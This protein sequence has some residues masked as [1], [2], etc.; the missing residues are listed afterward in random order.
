MWYPRDK[1]QEPV[2]LHIELPDGYRT[3]AAG[4]VPGTHLLWVAQKDL[5]RSYDFSD[6]A[7]I[8]ST[9]YVGGA[10]PSAIP[11]D[12]KSLLD[13]ASRP[14]TP[15]HNPQLRRLRQPGEAATHGPQLD[16]DYLPSM[17]L[18]PIDVWRLGSR[19]IVFP[20]GRAWRRIPQM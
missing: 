11:A 7:L 2:P 3:W 14:A 8:K 19:P 12:V 15:R 10:P 6:P 5:L 4:W 1:G 13:G 9:E 20:P 16:D 17:G 18:V